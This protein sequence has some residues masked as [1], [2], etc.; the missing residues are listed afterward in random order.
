MVCALFRSQGKPLGSKQNKHGQ[1]FTNAQSW[2]VLSGFAPEDRAVR[3]LEAVYLRLN[4]CNGIKLSTP[5][6]NGFD[7]EKGGVTTYPP[8]AKENGESSCMPIPG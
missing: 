7:P 2:A 1:I 4:T 6:Y 8:G 3:V 5:G